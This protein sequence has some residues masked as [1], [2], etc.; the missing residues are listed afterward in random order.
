MHVEK[1][2]H[3]QPK[4][5]SRRQWQNDGYKHLLAGIVVSER[6]VTYMTTPAEEPA[7][8][9]SDRELRLLN[10][11]AGLELSPDGSEP[12][13][14]SAR[15]WAQLSL[16][17][18][19]PGPV[20]EWVRRNNS[21]T[22][23][24]SPGMTTAK[25]GSRRPAY[26]FGVIPR[27]LMT[28]MTTEAVRTGSRQLHLGPSLSK[29]LRSLGMNSS[30][31]SSARALDQLHRL[32]VANMNIEDLRTSGDRWGIAGANFN[33]ASRYELWFS[34][35]PAKA[36]SDILGSTITLSEDFY[37][38][39]LEAPVPLRPEAL[40]AL[41]G[42]PM[43]LDLYAWLVYRLKYL[44]RPTTV[45]WGQLAGQFGADYKV[46]RQFKA[47]FEKNLREVLVLYPQA[48]T[49]VTE[50]GI[51]LLPSAE[52]IPDRKLRAI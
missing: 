25:D 48:K 32:A 16:P 31:A 52:H 30:G 39:V 10:V 22:L 41:S 2:R 43:R 44:E 51:R 34:K 24:I 26:P 29:F 47:A 1:L 14:Y 33:V 12:L 9:I 49:L 42:S 50:T 46:K 23:S 7:A 21:I 5:P 28:W 8:L 20:P 36:P 45:S 15:L 38:S 35:D 4:P 40:R 6:L 11:G 13:S 17:Y 18:R 3:P 19:D 27:Y 37:R